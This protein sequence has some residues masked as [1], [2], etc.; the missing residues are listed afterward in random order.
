PSSMKKSV[1]TFLD[2][3][4]N[5]RCVLVLGDMYELG[6]NISSFHQ[7]VGYYLNDYCDSIEFLVTVG[8]HSSCLS[9]VFKGNKRHFE[10]KEEATQY[11]K[12]FMHND[13]ALFF[14]ASRGMRLETIVNE[15]L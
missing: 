4:K 10:N 13:F 5:K 9:S 6:E 15:L 11:I 14:K 2:I 1:A 7:E 12:S 8:E 3:F